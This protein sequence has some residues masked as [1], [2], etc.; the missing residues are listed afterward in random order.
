MS[1]REFVHRLWRKLPPEL[2]RRFYR[3][4]TESVAPKASLQIDIPSHPG[5][6]FTVAGCL[7]APTGIGEAARLAAEALVAAGHE[8]SI[9]DLTEVLRHPATLPLPDLPPAR[10][11]A[12][13]VLVFAQPPTVAHAM[14]A[15][16]RPILSGKRRI[17]CWV[18]DLAVVP[19]DWRAQLKF[20]HELA[21]PSTFVA[22]SFAR[23]FQQPVRRLIHPVAVRNFTHEVQPATVTRFAA[24]MDLVSTVARKNPF[25]V[26]A[27]YRAAFGASDPVEL[28]VKLRGAH[29]VP[30]HLRE[31]E[32]LV[33]EP[34]PRITVLDQDLSAEELERWW[35]Q[36]DVLVSLH[37]SEGFG[38]LVAEAMR[39]GIPVISTDWSAT[40][41]YV[42]GEVGWPV[43][44]T[45]VSVIDESGRYEIPG[46]MWAEPNAS[47][48]VR[49][50]REAAFDPVERAAK[51]RRA[52]DRIERLFGYEAFMAGLGDGGWIAP[53]SEDC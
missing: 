29:A 19:R 33:R 24:A 52:R 14:H 46:A 11:G 6:P 42:D 25:A 9:F 23:A 44:A 35:S 4:A 47:A 37:R 20:V 15:I 26:V 48:A 3:Y 21:A 2:R 10:P 32:R 1:Q 49:A 5:P 50:L 30:A 36:V 39:R 53:P 12:G 45:E 27:A 16:G 28:T 8:V 18:W 34:G 17:G 51:G 38:L 7:R 31:L 43:A 40:R 13:S 41:E 22:R